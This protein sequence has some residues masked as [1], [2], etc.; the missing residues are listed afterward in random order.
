MC[1]L[2]STTM[3]HTGMKERHQNTLQQSQFCPA[4]KGSLLEMKKT[5]GGTGK[6][7]LDQ[8]K[9]RGSIHATINAQTGRVGRKEEEYGRGTVPHA[10]WKTEGGM[11]RMA[12]G[13]EVAM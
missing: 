4:S 1:F 9:V 5:E 8:K 3:L 2:M 12:W 6:F 10:P 11:P 13:L 7:L